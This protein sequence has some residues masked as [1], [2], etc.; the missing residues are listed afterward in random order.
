M[1][2]SFLRGL[3]TLTLTLGLTDDGLRP[4]RPGAG[5]D[6]TGVDP[7]RKLRGTR[8]HRGA[9]QGLYAP[10]RQ[11]E[12]VQ[13]GRLLRHHARALC[14]RRGAE[15]AGGASGRGPHPVRQLHPA[16][17][18]LYLAVLPDRRG[19]PR[20]PCRGRLPAPR[21]GAEAQAAAAA[22]AEAEPSR[23]RPKP[24]C[25]GSRRG[26]SGAAAA[27][28]RRSRRR[29]SRQPK[30]RPPRPQ[31]PPPRRPRPER[32]RPKR[33]RRQPQLPR[34]RPAAALAEAEA[35]AAAQPKPRQP[36]RSP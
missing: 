30:R 8:Q 23:R 33:S 1:L 27:A 3:A 26:R 13:R 12:R 5:S 14:P 7:D 9:D 20:R 28:A 32:Q 34:P 16:A 29:S 19:P 2:T 24:S 15:R 11:R 4:A 22:E 10:V 31:K 21:P 36:P 17:S 6:R 25:S 18:G 35:E